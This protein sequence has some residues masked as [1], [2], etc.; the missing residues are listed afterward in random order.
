MIPVNV[1]EAKAQLSRLLREVE[2]GGEVVIARAGRP[3]ARLVAYER[4]K[5]PRR[6]GGWQGKIQIAEDFDELPDDMLDAFDG[7]AP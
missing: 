3:I 1:H 7:R 2:N 4:S 5:E 6:L